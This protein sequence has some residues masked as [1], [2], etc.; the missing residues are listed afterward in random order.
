ML[1]RLLEKVFDK[2]DGISEK[3]RVDFVPP[4]WSVFLRL[5]PKEVLREDSCDC[6]GASS[7]A[8]GPGILVGGYDFWILFG[9]CA[10]VWES[11]G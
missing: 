7:L 6:R 5:K 4:D 3:R 2:D 10:G 1:S 8:I 9:T 11:E